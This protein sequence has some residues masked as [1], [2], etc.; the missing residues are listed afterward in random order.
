MYKL[1]FNIGGVS[2][3]KPINAKPKGRTIRNDEVR[4]VKLG[5]KGEKRW[6]EGAESAELQMVIIAELAFQSKKIELVW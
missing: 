2:M 4:T 3:D 1:D 6:T 5:V